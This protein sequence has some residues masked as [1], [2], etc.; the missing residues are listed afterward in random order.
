MLDW[1]DLRTILAVTRAG[2]AAGAAQILGVHPSTV[3]RRIQSME[4]KL[5]VS[6]FQRLPD[7]YVPTAAGEE[8]STVAEQLES[9]LAVLDRRLAGRDLR[10]S[11]VLRVTTTDTLVAVLSPQIAAFRSHYP[12]IEVRLVVTNRFHDLTRHDADIALRPTSRPPET[13][14]GRPLATVAAAVY[15]AADKPEG[16][17]WLAPDET[18]EHLPYA[19]WLQHQM[20]R[21]TIAGRFNSL[22]TALHLARSGVGLCALPCFLA[23]PDPQLKRVREPDPTFATDLW[24]L[25]HPDLRR[26]ARVKAFYDFIGSALKPYRAQFEGGQ[27]KALG[28]ES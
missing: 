8:A 3:F 6:F 27:A 15:G 23:D 21:A 26:V 28:V 2:T 11:G 17:A 5:G 4:R 18:L 24:L 1:E 16:N 25:T 13:L 20:P 12:E 7:G 10:P 19:R 14:I 22:M 9:E